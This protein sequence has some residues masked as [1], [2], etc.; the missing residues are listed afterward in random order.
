MNIDSLFSFE[1]TCYLVFNKTDQ[2]LNIFSIILALNTLKLQHSSV[3]GR[4]LSG[5]YA[6]GMPDTRPTETEEGI[7]ED[8]EHENL[9]DKLSHDSTPLLMKIAQHDRE[10]VN[11]L[12]TNKHS[13]G[14]GFYTGM[15]PY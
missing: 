11:K 8:N 6:G 12:W 7:T 14:N 15:T 13:P 9:E 5:H 4:S 3:A 1:V 2:Q 10:D